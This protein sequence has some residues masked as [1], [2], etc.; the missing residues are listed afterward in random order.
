MA[1]ALSEFDLEFRPRAAIK[2]QVLADFI[3]EASY[4]EEEAQAK[5]W[6]VS[7]DGSATQTGSGDGIIITSPGETSSN[8]L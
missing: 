8:M 5:T 7:V 6:E 2:A 3:V 4:K 1:I